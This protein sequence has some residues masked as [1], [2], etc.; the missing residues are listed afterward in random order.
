MR[1][2]NP[3]RSQALPELHIG[4]DCLEALRLR[5]GRRKLRPVSF[6]VVKMVAKPLDYSVFLPFINL[7]LDLIEREVN[8]VVMMDFFARQFVAQLQPELVQ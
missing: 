6:D 1:D 5:L 8:D 2:G 4:T 7:A 3:H